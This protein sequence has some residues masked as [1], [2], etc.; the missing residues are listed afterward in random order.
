M[1]ISIIINIIATVVILGIDL[2]RQNFKQ[3]KYSSVLIALTING[4]INLFIVGEYDYISFFTILLFLA[5]TL[6]QLYINRVVDVFV[7]K[8]QKFIAVVLTIILSTSTI[9]TYS[10]SHDSYYM[11]IP[12]L[13]PAIA[14]IGAIFLFYSTFQPEEQMHFKLINKIKRP[15]LI[16]N[17]MLIMSF[18]LMTLLTPYWYAF[19]II[20]IVF[21]AFIFWQNIFSK[22]ND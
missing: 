9:L 8:E 13:A 11:S 10:T 21:I 12:Y 20:Y 6:L 22:Q 3:L 1:L 19:L 17:L 5:W 4:L 16:G 2:Y 14:L 15:I 7:I 18:I